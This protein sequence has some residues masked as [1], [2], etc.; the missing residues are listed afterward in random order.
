MNEQN[1]HLV[2]DTPA[3][4]PEAMELQPATEV[5]VVEHALGLEAKVKEQTAAIEHLMEVSG[6]FEAQ[7]LKYKTA[8]EAI[9]AD[10]RASATHVVIAKKALG[11]D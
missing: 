8:L 9:I 11:H 2:T 4:P 1:E 10:P 5:M 7:A 6:A 3:F